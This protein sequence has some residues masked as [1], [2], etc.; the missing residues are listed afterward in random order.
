MSLYR[1][2]LLTI[3]GLGVTFLILRDARP[4]KDAL[5]NKIGIFI[6]LSYAFYIP[7]IL[8]VQ[9]VPMIGMLMIPK[10]LMYVV[11]AWLAYK[12]IFLPQT[13]QSA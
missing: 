12:Q 5:F 9:K 6:L 1:N 10:T 8:F 4:E 7:V 13:S 3:Q 2:V 11:I